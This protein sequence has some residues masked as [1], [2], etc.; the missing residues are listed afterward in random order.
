[1]Y[2][3]KIY[4]G[5]ICHNNQEWYKNLIGT[6]LSFLNYHEELLT[7][8]FGKKFVLISYLWPK[9]IMFE[10]QKYRGVIFHDTEELCKFLRKTDLQFDSKL[11]L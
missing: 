6:D 2:E 11:D 3:L 10:L 9:Y 4:R 8:T 7:Q 5:V 1:M